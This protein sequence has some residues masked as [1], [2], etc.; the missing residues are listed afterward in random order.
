MLGVHYTLR[1]Y[2]LLTLLCDITGWSIS[3]TTQV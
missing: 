3:T 2:Y 1:F